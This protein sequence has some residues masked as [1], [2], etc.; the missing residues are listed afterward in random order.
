MRNRSR[1]R[2]TPWPRAVGL[3]DYLPFASRALNGSG[4][5]SGLD[6]WSSRSYW[7][8]HIDLP[9]E[10]PM[11]HSVVLSLVLGPAL[12]AWSAFSSRSSATPDAE[13]GRYLV[14]HVAMC[15]QCHT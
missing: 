4:C 8:F 14:H 5:R 11:K 6:A 3:G 13:H 1:C 2:R 9:R 10:D 7:S 12:L 15:I